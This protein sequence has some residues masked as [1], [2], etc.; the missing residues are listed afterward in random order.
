[1]SNKALLFDL[2]LYDC[3]LICAAADD[4]RRLAHIQVHC[5][6]QIARCEFTKCVYDAELTALEFSNYILG[7]TVQKGASDVLG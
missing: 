2:D 3:D 7:L 6:G 5:D 4:Y 1:M